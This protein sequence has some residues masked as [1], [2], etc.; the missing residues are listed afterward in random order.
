[1]ATKVRKGK[2]SRGKGEVEIA[3]VNGMPVVSSLKV[4]EHFQKRHDHVLAS[5]REIVANTPES[6]TAP[7]FRASEYTDSTGRRL[8]AFDLSRD[9]FALV[10][11]GFTG[12][13]ALIWK[14][15]YIEAFNAM[16]NTI[17]KQLEGNYSQELEGTY[18]ESGQ[19]FHFKQWKPIDGEKIKGVIGWMN[20]WCQIDNLE[21]GEAIKQLCT[22]LQ[23][24][25][26]QEIQEEDTVYVYNFIWCSLFKIR[27]KDGVELTKEQ[28]SAFNGILLFW[29]KCLGESSEN[30]I[31]FICTKCNIKSFGEI[32]QHSL[33][34][35]LNAALLGIFRHVFCNLSDKV[36]KI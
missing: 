27:N 12:S 19:Q 11:M 15:R 10:I 4:A 18:E 31:S 16:E 6:F 13:E 7:N 29:E 25:N 21:F 5:I 24:N 36:Y 22:V 35:A 2:S 14:I 33:D 17:Q 3:L 8:P 23:V 20:Y 26:L 28:Q 1:M 9:A 30:I 32:K 34:K